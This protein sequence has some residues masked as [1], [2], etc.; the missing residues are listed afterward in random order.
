[1]GKRKEIKFLCKDGQTREGRQDGVMFWIRKDQKREQDGLP[2]FYVAANDI[3]GKGRTIYTAGHEYFTLEGAKELCQQIMAGEANLAERKA[4]YAAEDMEK[5]R[6]AV[7]SATEQAK[8]F[9]DKLEATGISY[10]ELLALEQATANCEELA[11]AIREMTAGVLTTVNSF[12]RWVQRVVAEVAA[13]QEM[14]TA[15]R[16]ASVDN[17]PLYNRYRHTKKKRI[18]KKYAKRILEW[19]RTEVAPC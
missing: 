15:L 4:K 3:K 10:H 18:R 8:A 7:A 9:R 19:Y 5:E 6:R 12:C 2:A 13:Q 1:M 17:R 16:W 14:E 11:K